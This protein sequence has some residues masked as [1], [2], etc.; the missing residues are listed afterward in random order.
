MPS[1]QDHKIIL[2]FDFGL[3]KI[4][5][6]IGQTLTKSARPLALITS[7]D[8][9][10]DAKQLENLLQQW[11]PHIIVVGLPYS[12]TR[13]KSNN[14]EKFYAFIKCLEQNYQAKYN[15]IIKTVD[16]SQSS[17][18]AKEKFKLL[19]KSNLAKKHDKLDPIAASI[20]LQRYFDQNSD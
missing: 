17:L 16:E 4:G 9:I 8:G 18:E 1:T 14:L 7:K 10:A 3:K 13:N 12:D 11:S 15:F 5:V 20:I 19:R 6:A 2:A